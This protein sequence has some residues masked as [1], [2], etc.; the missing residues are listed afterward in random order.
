MATEVTKIVDPDGTAGV[1][2]DYTSLAALVAGYAKNLVTA[3][4]QLT[5]KCRCTGGTADGEVTINGFTTDATR[6]IKIWTDPSD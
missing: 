5:V 2:C 1:N 6:F 3:D 4:E